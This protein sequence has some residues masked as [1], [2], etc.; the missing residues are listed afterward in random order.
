MTTTLE[1]DNANWDLVVDAS[2]NIATITGGAQLA[3]DAASACRLF[4]GELWFDTT[5][6]VPYW[7]QLLGTGV[8]PPNSLIVAKLEAA[9]MTVS[10][11]QTAS[12]A[13]KSITDRTVTG[14]VTVTGAV[15][16]TPVSASASF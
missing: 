6:G 7:Q 4:L 12:V 8:A 15:G 13:I 11:V 2:G 1:L 3:Q 9:A 14:T 5:Q 10:G 16:G